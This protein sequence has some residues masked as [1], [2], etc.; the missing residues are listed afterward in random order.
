MAGAFD[1][2]R[3]LRQIVGEDAVQRVS[4]GVVIGAVCRKGHDRL[5]VGIGRG[6]D[7]A[8]GDEGVYKA[9]RPSRTIGQCERGPGR[10][11]PER[12]RQRALLRQP[13]PAGGGGGRLLGG[14]W[15]GG[16]RDGQS[17]RQKKGGG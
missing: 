14:D 17:Q 1:F 13:E 11:R 12:R 15:R 5:D 3:P 10:Q 2:R 8:A 6:D 16:G 4:G 7:V 9:D